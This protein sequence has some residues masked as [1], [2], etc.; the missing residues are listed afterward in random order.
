MNN[1]FTPDIFFLIDET[2]QP[3]L[4]KRS[5]L[6]QKFHRQ[7]NYAVYDFAITSFGSNDVLDF[8]VE[9]EQKRLIS[10]A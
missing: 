4:E 7:K 1:I 8:S 5:I 3:C 9:I 2:N 10:K 6:C